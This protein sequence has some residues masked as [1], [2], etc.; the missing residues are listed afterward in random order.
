[1]RGYLLLLA[2]DVSDDYVSWFYKRNIQVL[3][4][5]L[6]DAAMD[7]ITLINLAKIELFRY[8]FKRLD[9]VLYLD[10]DMLVRKS[11]NQ[12]L[13]VS[14]IADVQGIS[15]TTMAILHES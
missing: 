15:K 7:F 1:L 4:V 9:Q 8:G 14:G 6:F 5:K 13:D 3:R 2:F 11:L 10:A 12:I